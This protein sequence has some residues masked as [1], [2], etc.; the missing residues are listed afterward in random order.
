MSHFVYPCYMHTQCDE[1][2]ICRLYIWICDEYKY[3]ALILHHLT[4]D[5]KPTANYIAKYIDFFED[6]NNYYL[7]TE[8]IGGNLSDFCNEAH[9]YI[10]NGKL[11]IKDW[12]KIIKYLFW[13]LSVR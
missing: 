11:K 12:K 6:D 1:C 4:I 10:R 9:E 5:N 3:I 7:V 8:F 13:Q 2:C